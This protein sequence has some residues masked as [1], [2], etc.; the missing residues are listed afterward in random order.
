MVVGPEMNEK[1]AERNKLR[2]E[3]RE[4]GRERKFQNLKE[5]HLWEWKRRRR[6]GREG[7]KDM[8]SR[9]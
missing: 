4:K 9:M 6:R 5:L 8:K 3:I 7:E 2:R 1:T